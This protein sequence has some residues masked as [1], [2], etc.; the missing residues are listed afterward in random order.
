MMDNDPFPQIKKILLRMVKA[1]TATSFMDGILMICLNCDV[2]I[3]TPLIDDKIK[4]R[5]LNNLPKVP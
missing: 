2:A 4:V 1:E 3:I 5:E